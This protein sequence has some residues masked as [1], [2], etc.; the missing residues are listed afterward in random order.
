MPGPGAAA[1][2]KYLHGLDYA[3]LAAYF[4]A[5]LAIGWACSRRS[6]RSSDEFMR[7]GGRLPWCVQEA[8]RVNVFF[9]GFIAVVACMVIG[10]VWSLVFAP[11][12]PREA[13]L[14]EG[15][16]SFPTPGG[17]AAA[18]GSRRFRLRRLR[19]GAEMKG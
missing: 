6:G 10:Y 1:P 7:G 8:T 11:R 3:V 9:Q 19:R 4:C 5:N 15:R 2:P 12:S 18:R 14:F 13:G 16:I 17:M